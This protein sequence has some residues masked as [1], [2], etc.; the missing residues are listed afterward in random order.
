M[1]N[2][3]NKS[4]P[5]KNLPKKRNTSL[6]NFKPPPIILSSN[7]RLLINKNSNV[8]SNKLLPSLNLQPPPIMKQEKPPSL[9]QEKR[10]VMSEQKPPPATENILDNE[11]LSSYHF[12]GS[13][14]KKKHNKKEENFFKTPRVVNETPTLPVNLKEFIGDH[15]DQGEKMRAYLLTRRKADFH[16]KFFKEDTDLMYISLSILTRQKQKLTPYRNKK[17]KKP[18]CLY[19]LEE[20]IAKYRESMFSNYLSFICFNCKKVIDLNNFFMD[21]TLNKIIEEIWKKYNRFT[22]QCKEVTLLRT[23]FWEP[24]LPEYL[25]LLDKNLE[26]TQKKHKVISRVEDIVEVKTAKYLKKNLKWFEDYTAEEYKELE[27]QLMRKKFKSN[28]NILYFKTYSINMQDYSHLKNESAFPVALM[29]LFIQ[30]VDEYQQKNHEKFNK[31]SGNKTYI[32]GIKVTKYDKFYKKARYE[33][34]PG[35]QHIY[36]GKTNYII[37]LYSLVCMML[38]VENRWVC[39][40]IDLNTY[41]YYPIDFLEEGLSEFNVNSLSDL[42]MYLAK[43]EMNINLKKLNLYNVNKFNYIQDFGVNICAFFYKFLMNPDMVEITINPKEK[44][45]FKKQF[46]WLI[47]KHAD[48]LQK[49]IAI[50][51]FPKTK[52]ELEAEERLFISFTI[53]TILFFVNKGLKKK[54][55]Y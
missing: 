20:L 9:I 30:Y 42:S 29:S 2:G 46:C 47:L 41:D 25:K 45:L 23:G 53:L 38:L 22:L 33:Y 19:D 16:L 18:D 15:M 4:S 3:N 24:N 44:A 17:C 49:Q 11:S 54:E 6:S 34:L 12:Q 7:N 50:F 28:K 31:E 40:L 39:V 26:K 13:E 1:G 21:V 55:C 32:F 14:P 37:E 43:K 8:D 36:K 48:V 10:P 35:P 52:A 27:T 51:E 5:S